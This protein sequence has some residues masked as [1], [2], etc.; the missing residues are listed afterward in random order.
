MTRVRGQELHAPETLAVRS[1][2]ARETVRSANLR[3]RVQSSGALRRKVQFH[4][5]GLR[6]NKAN[7]NVHV[8]GEEDVNLEEVE[9]IEA[10]KHRMKLRSR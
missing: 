1:T 2:R 9:G 4:L 6:M 3:G 7:V 5:L 10:D 8:D